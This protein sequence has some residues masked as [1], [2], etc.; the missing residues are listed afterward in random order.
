MKLIKYQL[1]ASL[2]GWM[3]IIGVAGVAV[4][5]GM[6]L[7]PLYLESYTVDTILEDVALEY[8]NK[9]ANKNQ[10]WSSISKRLDVNSINDIKKENFFYKKDN[11]KT[12]ISLKYEVRTNLVG[13]LDGI[14]SF[15]YAQIIEAQHES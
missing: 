8:R 1:G 11:G 3:V 15:E 10:I 4:V 14:A 9:R 6:R 12:V 5:L 7:V 2:L 13:N